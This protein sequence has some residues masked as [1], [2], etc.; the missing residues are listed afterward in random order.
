MN[1]V[2]RIVKEEFPLFLASPTIVWQFLF[3]YLPLLVMIFFSFLSA[4]EEGFRFS[5]T[6][7]HYFR[8]L[9]PVYLQI[10]INSFLLALSTSVLCLFIG[11]PIAYFISLKGG[12][13][14]MILLILIILPSWSNLIVQI[15]A[16]FFLLDP[17]GLLSPLLRYIG[18][19]SKPLHILNTI[20]AILI[21]MVYVF[22]PFMIL[23]IYAV[24]SKM[25]KKLL[26]ASADL[27]ANRFNTL[28]RIVFPLSLPGIY[29]GF[30]LVFIPAFGEYAIPS[31]LGGSKYVFWGNVIVDKFLV[32]RDW[33]S[34]F[35]LAWSGIVF[36]ILALLML[37]VFSFLYKKL[38]ST[39]KD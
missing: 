31:L 4:T 37:N 6:L 35:A 1:I 33:S 13:W 39:F 21:G 23:P 20:Y 7:Q 27:G 14:K 25:D 19:I 17:N 5:I 24:L 16:W 9:K 10:I 32:V 22:L 15:Y 30:L 8:I 28:R 18:V 26:E 36:V 12:I 38:F 3:L 29:T 34:G 11:F 2:R